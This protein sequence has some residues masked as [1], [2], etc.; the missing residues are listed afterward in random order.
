M[1]LTTAIRRALIPLSTCLPLLAAPVA[2]DDVYTTLEDT[3]ASPEGP[4]LL[5]VNFDAG[6]DGFTYADNTFGTNAGNNAAGSHEASGGFGSSGGLEV[7]V[8][9]R[10]PNNSGG[11]RQSS[12]GWQRTFNL[13]AAGTLQFSGRYRLQTLGGMEDNEYGD[14]ILD[15]DGTRYGP[16]GTAPALR[17]ARLLGPNEENSGNSAESDSGWQTF[18]LSIPL[19]AGSHT[20]TLGVYNNSSTAFG[21]VVQLNLDDVV[22]GPPPGS[23][24]VLFNDTGGTGTV[25]ATRLTSPANGVLTFGANGNFTYTPVLNWS[26]TDSFTYRASD[27]TGASNPATV[28]INVTPV[29]DAPAGGTDNYSTAEDTPLTV[30]AP[31]VLA[32]DTDVDSAVLT[33]VNVTQPANGTVT[34]NSSGSFTYTPNS[35][36]EGVDAFTYQVSDGALESPPV[37]VNLTVTGVPDAPETADDTYYTPSGSALIVNQASQ[38]AGSNVT[39]IIAAPDTPSGGTAQPGDPWKYLDNGTD[40]GTAWQALE[41]DDS[42]WRTGRGELGYGDADGENRPE[43]TVI[44]DN[45]VPGY[46]SNAS[47]RYITTYFR[48]V[49]EV[50]DFRRISGLTMSLLRDDGA[51]VWLNGNRV[52][53]ENGLN[54]ATYQTLTSGSIGNEATH[55]SIPLTGAEQY[56]RDGENVLAVE[57]HQ[58]ST[59]SSDMSF[60]L[61][62]TALDRPYGGVLANDSDPEGQPMTAAVVQ[63]PAHGTL[64]F[65][66]NGTF[67]YNAA[68]GFQGTDTFTYTAS[69]GSLT[70]PPATVTITVGPPFNQPPVAAPNTY[71]GTEDTVLTVAAA[72][73]VLANDADPESQPLTAV[74][75]SQSANGTVALAP[76]GSFTFTPAA[77][78]NGATTFTY[79][80]SDGLKLSPITTVTLN[81][82]AVPDV[83]VAVEDVYRTSTGTPLVVSSVSPGTTSPVTLI[84]AAPETTGGVA[85]PGDTWRYLDNGTDQG[86]AWQAIDFNDSGWKEGAGE[87]GYGDESDNRPEITVI[88]DDDTPGYSSSSNRYITYY[89]RKSFSIADRLRVSNL[90]MSLLR[91]DGA[92]VYLNG[93]RLHA[94][95]SLATASPLTYLTPAD[96]TSNESTHELIPLPNAAQHLVDGLNVLAVEVHQNNSTSSDV[97]FDLGLV[98]EEAGYGGVLHNDRDPEG[99]SFTASLV[100]PP[101]NGTL[102]LAPNGTFTY[103]PTPGY[104]GTDTFTYRAVDAT[105]PSAPATVSIIVS[106]GVNQRPAAAADAYSPVEDATFTRSAAQ[107][108]LANDTDPDGDALSAVL[109]TSTSNGSLTL[110]AD[111]SFTYLASPNYSGPDSFTYRARDS[112]NLYS[113]AVVVS[114]TVTP[115]NDPPDAA[116]ETYGTDPGQTLNVPIGQGVLI[117]DSDIDGDNLTAQL[118]APPASG[119]L[120]LSANGAFVYTPAAAGTFTFTYAAFDGTV[121]SAPATVTLIV[122]GRPVAAADSYTTDEDA[123][124]SRNAPGVLG[125]DTD[126]ENEPLSADL[127]TPPASG[128]L[129]FTAGGS[130]TYTPNANYFGS[131]SFTYTVT[132]GKRTSLPATVSITVTAVNDVPVAGADNY[133]VLKD[134]PLTISAAN[135]VLRND[136]DVDSPALTA[137]LVQTTSSGALTLNSDGSFN[138]TPNSGYTGP[139]TF[140]YRAGDG[141]LQSTDTTVTLNV[142]EVV[143][144]VLI[145]E[146]M[147]NPTNGVAA[148]E[149]IELLNYGSVA[150]DLGGWKF[151]AGVNY[152]FPSPTPLPAGGRIVVP[153]DPAAFDARWPGVNNRTSTGW[154]AGGS[155]LSNSGERIRLERPDFTQPGEFISVN[156]IEYSDEGDWAVRRVE[157][158][159]NNT[160]WRWNSGADGGGQ[161]LQLRTLQI[162]NEYGH[163]WMSADP[164]PGAANTAAAATNLAPVILDVK[165]SPAV[166]GPAQQV[167]I[168]CELVDENTAGLSA[169]A[170][171]RLAVSNPA[172]F[173]A[174][175]MFDDGLH[176]DGAAGDG[177][178]GAALPAQTA[179]SIVEFYVTA[180]D[181]AESRSWPA[182]ALSAGGNPL[183]QA[184]SAN[185]FYQV[186]P[187]AWAGDQ[188]IYR[189]IMSR[190]EGDAFVSTDYDRGEGSDTDKNVT[191]IFGQGEDMDIRY[192]G[193]VRYRGAGSRGSYRPHNWKLNL[194]HD[195]PWQDWS[196][197]NLNSLSSHVLVLGSRLMQ[198]A[199]LATEIGTATAVRFNGENRMVTGNPSGV[200]VYGLYS[201]QTP[202]GSE[203]ADLAFPADPG[204][205]IYKKGRGG[206]AGWRLRESSPGVPNISGYQNDAWFK[207]TNVT[208]NDWTDLNDFIRTMR[209]ATSNAVN[210]PSFDFD[211]ASTVADLEQWARWWAFCVIINHRETNL[212][213]GVDDDYSI[214]IRKSDRK[215]MLLA[216]DF[217]TTFGAGDTS[218]SPAATIWQAYDTSFVSEKSFTSAGLDIPRAMFYNNRFVRRFKWHLRDLLNTV[219]S[220]A[221]FDAVV[222]SALGATT[223]SGPWVPQSERD[224]LRSFMNSRRNYILTQLPSAFTA[225]TNLPVSN[226][227]PTTTSANDT[228]MSGFLDGAI[229]D[230]VLINGV[231]ASVNNH[232]NTWTAAGV[233]AGLLPGINTVNVTALDAAGAVVGSRTLV[234]H[235]DDGSTAAKDGSLAADEIWSAAGGPYLISTGVTVPSGVTL[236]IQPGAS[237]YLAAG[238]GLTV[239]PGG[240]LVAEGTPDRLIRFTRPPGTAGTWGGI[241]AAGSPEVRLSDAVI[242]FNDSTAISLTGGSTGV[243][244]RLT[245]LNG[246]RASLQ[247]DASSWTV[248]R[249]SFPAMT[250]GSSFTTVNGNGIAAG[251]QGVIRDCSFGA[252][253]GNND[254]IRFSNCHRPGPVLRVLNCE[255]AG[256]G[257]DLIELRSADAWIEGN[258]FAHVHKA[259]TDS[260]AAVVAGDSGSGKSEVTFVRNFVYDCDIA[261]TAK[262][263]SSAA[264]LYNTIANITKTGGSETQSAV[265]NLADTLDGTQTGAGAVLTGNV[266]AVAEGLTRQYQGAL[267]SVTFSGNIL[268][269]AWSGPGSGN[270]VVA[271][272]LLNLAG[273]TTPAT[274]TAAQIRTALAP[275]LCSPA[276]GSGIAGGDLGATLP[277]GI[278][279]GG[280]PPLTTALDSASIQPGPAGVFAAP[281]WNFGYT[282]YRWSS[283]GTTW[284]ADTPVSTPLALTGLSSGLQTLYLLGRE[285]SGVWQTVPTV[286]TWNV[287]TALPP[288]MLSE[289]LA[290]NLSAYP[291]GATRPD[292]IELHNY[293]PAGVSL[294]GFGLTDE[295]DTPFKFTFPSGVVI[296]AGGYLLVMADS[297]PPQSGELHTGFGLDAGGEIIS[298]TTPAGVLADRVTFGPQIA[299]RSVARTGVRLGW[300]LAT[301]TPAAANAAVC[302]LGPPSGLRLNEWLATND[303]IVEDDFVEIYNPSPKPVNLS[304]M[305]LTDNF[306]SLNALHAMGDSAVHVIAPLSFIAGSGFVSFIADGNEENGGDH[307]SF[308]LAQ[309]HET[310]GLADASGIPVDYAVLS[311]AR[312]DISEG[313]AADGGIATA[314]FTVPTPGFSNTT[315]LTLEVPLR[316]ALRITEIMYNPSSSSQP[317]FIEFRNTGATPLDLTGV[318]FTSGITFTFPSMILAPGAYTVITDNAARFAASYPG[319]TPA[320]V[321]SGRLDNAGE[322]LRF[323]I[324]EYPVGVL[325]FSYNDTWYPLTDGQG[326]SLQ[327]V[328]ASRPPSTWGDRESWQ[329]GV[330]SPGSTTGFGVVA[331][332]D[333]RTAYPAAAVLDGTLFTGQFAAGDITLAWSKVSG[334]GTVNFTAPPS[335]DTNVTFSAPGVYEL[336]LTATAPGPLTS[337]DHVLV[338][339]EENYDDWALRLLPGPVPLDRLRTADPDR[340]GLLNFMEYALGTHPGRND[341]GAAWTLSTADGFLS[342]DY[343]RNPTAVAGIQIIPQIADD[344]NAW[345]ESESGT[346]H[347]VIDTTGGVE[348]WRAR[349]VQPIIPGQRRY[350]RLKF[351]MP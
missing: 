283:N 185:C 32:N 14:F 158:V 88:E 274:A 115:A 76:D 30:T 117:N 239:N 273:I 221:N 170:Y 296:P 3:P 179:G 288:V 328:D 339:S 67:T 298:L 155:S 163:N 112:G 173:A 215:T 309:F 214:Y 194:P 271:D 217:D 151:D 75:V 55:E 61:G 33:A 267:S 337:L 162:S 102:S 189:L 323:E 172:A 244:E 29:N 72:N 279:A 220:Q 40:Q 66:A 69:D 59:S 322:R 51:V 121:Q 213:N 259:G 306:M 257:D 284:S 187:E 258:V 17:I 107:G 293:G 216:H 315:D 57:I 49:F 295:S 262:E 50:E 320:G 219:F 174:A 157:T 206:S 291:L 268:P 196:N 235:F 122:N 329:A 193:G 300:S 180:T 65:N 34:L 241:T 159:G 318:N 222:E 123:P 21:E 335:T 53:W 264:L 44:E 93:N 160:G 282:H 210:P 141:A 333:R 48:K 129:D 186:D 338:I 275:Q 23:G 342:L 126:P 19:T 124:L 272:A 188:P 74:L 54:N 303:F 119:T 191:V 231:P 319:V 270:V 38:P 195:R 347:G 89:F 164:T 25:T 9:N 203:W 205:N 314:F 287:N 79:R 345:D 143:E 208:E 142:A 227:F 311:V 294:A 134:T 256:S 73:G 148:Q 60:D 308:K 276:A 154:A 263:G 161:S 349:D 165:H 147:F 223:G 242:E 80:A 84:V 46:T 116:G 248:S 140:I 331:G 190:P 145:S 137:T 200:A 24:S 269:A 22:I 169:T 166:P 90:S 265:L 336:R 310:L 31:G 138:Y 246:A 11:G 229:T 249:C 240:R 184:A 230:R 146:I 83:P 81:F 326:A 175:P 113:D 101:A 232:D 39:F 52:F 204:G 168:T 130:F 266:I 238:A 125:N 254:V 56:L 92:V 350:L 317:E 228:G 286:V 100:T 285:D 152:I 133:G 8:G 111:G 202:M 99:N 10:P 62:L 68:A 26:G 297:L 211:L 96:N 156:E 2:V 234:I 261:V 252:V 131:D 109:V 82:A 277:P 94:D 28:T 305:M 237:V 351:I 218:S 178:F 325:D 341:A 299:D 253:S 1:T 182:P 302:D 127:I 132:D 98:A 91:D 87:L 316:N 86:T 103:T 18:A 6:A 4:P 27:S 118:V 278:A 199:G 330:P 7:T 226:G 128:T 37:T 327:I 36:H 58:Q 136:T 289:V 243:L 212:S 77:D 245:F 207:E 120:N 250:A 63:Q 255:F 225:V 114:L 307:L 64:T 42:T 198:G 167:H 201:H 177:T 153:A 343:R 45:P 20:L 47:D 312:R 236:T 35:N 321:Y 16:E 85:Q 13:D 209:Q 150:V 43:F 78:W 5:S 105:G 290:S 340:D 181:G 71:N 149:Y 260:A 344:L 332:P 104:R 95:G 334:P 106:S 192:Q 313:R 110:N 324:A 171:W 301:F 70:S 135:G 292:V 97:S 12:G 183:S 233:A 108:V 41:F 304:G 197:F 348:T 176:N 280:L 247:L 346:V 139:D 224:R 281:A 15:V 251:G 144:T